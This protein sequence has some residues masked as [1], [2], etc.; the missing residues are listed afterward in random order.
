MGY[1]TVK[2]PRMRLDILREQR[3]AAQRRLTWAVHH[4]RPWEEIEDKSNVVAAL[5]WAV[6]MAAKAVKEEER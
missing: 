6:E 5:K 1:V 2:W 4:N 3:D